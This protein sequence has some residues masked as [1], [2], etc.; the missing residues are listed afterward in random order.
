MNIEQVEELISSKQFQQLKYFQEKTNVFTIVGQTHTEHWHSAFISWLLDPN[1]S[2]CLGHYPLVRLLTLYMIKSEA[3]DL[4]LKT[5]F[6][7]NLDSV[8]FETEKTF[9]PPT[10]RNALLMFMVK[11]MSLF[12]S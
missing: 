4:S 11:A 6:N 2:L 1:S 8:R 12:L 7:M 3:T 10:G 5:V 9:L